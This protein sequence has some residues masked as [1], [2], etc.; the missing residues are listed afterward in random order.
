MEKQIYRNKAFLSYRHVEKDEKLASLLQKKLENY[1]IPRDLQKNRKSSGSLMEEENSGSFRKGKNVTDPGIRDNNNEEEGI[2]GN[3]LRTRGVGRIFRDT[4][5]L[6]ARAD[7][8]EELRRELDDSEYLIVLCSE[9]S[10]SSKWIEREIRYFLQFH[11]A[12]KILPVLTDGEPEEILPAIFEGIEGMP[13]HPIACDFRG[14]RRQALRDELPRLAAALIGC[15]YDQLVNRRQRYE[16]RRLAA[17]TAGIVLFLTAVI[18][19]YAF[20][21]AQIRKSLREKQ[22]EESESLAVQS[23]TAL[24]QRFQLDAVRYA[25]A[26]LPEVEGERPVTE[27]A[28][29]ALQKATAAYVPEGNRSIMQTGELK[30]PERIVAFQVREIGGAAYVSASC[31]NSDTVLWNADTGETILDTSAQPEIFGIQ[32]DPN[33]NIGERQFLAQDQLLVSV[34]GRVMGMDVRSGEVRWQ[35]KEENTEKYEIFDAGNGLVAVLAMM[36]ESAGRAPDN[37][38]LLTPVQELQLRRLEDGRIVRRM[39]NDQYPDRDIWNAFIDKDRVYLTERENTSAEDSDLTGKSSETGEDG[40]FEETTESGEREPGSR[41]CLSVLDLKTGEKRPLLRRFNI[42]D[43]QMTAD[44][45]VLAAYYNGFNQK[46]NDKVTNGDTF[47]DGYETCFFDAGEEILRFCCIDPETGE[48]VWEAGSGSML[49]G[50]SLLLQ[51]LHIRGREACLISVGTHVEILAQDLGEKLYSVDFPGIPVYLKT[52]EAW[53]Q[54]VLT[55]VLQDGSQVSY[56]FTTGELV[57]KEGVFPSSIS[58]VKEAG[59]NVFLL[60]GQ[61]GG[62]P[63]NDR[64]IR[65]EKE[66]FDPDVSYI[67]TPDGDKLSVSRLCFFGDNTIMEENSKLRTGGVYLAGEMFIVLD[68]EYTVH[69]VDA[70]TGAI[71]WSSSPGRNADCEGLAEEA[72]IMVFRDYLLSGDEIQEMAARGEVVHQEERWVFLHLEDGQTETMENFVENLFLGKQCDVRGIAFSGAAMDLPVLVEDKEV[73][74]LRY[75]LQ[76]RTMQSICLSHKTDKEIASALLFTAA[77]P[78]GNY[79]MCSFLPYNAQESVSL[80]ADWK[81]G[82]VTEIQNSVPVDGGS[83]M[84]WKK[85]ESAFAMKGQDSRTVLFAADGSRLEDF[86]EEKG[87]VKDL[88][89]W[90]GQL[91]TIEEEG[92]RVYFRIPQEKISYL[93]PVEKKNPYYGTFTDSKLFRTSELS[94]G[95]ILLRYGTQSFVLDADKGVA[96]AVIDNL[97]AYCPATDTM[98]LLD[99]TGSLAFSRRYSWKELVEK[100]RRILGD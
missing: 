35:V 66:A 57:K 11:D 18:V 9:A 79:T 27:Q 87:R 67:L 92:S 94:D 95:K 7:L 32:K 80:L 25:L 41:M 99:N 3:K 22:S 98:L 44:G 97:T 52:A 59:E 49:E 13:Q 71:L 33:L 5:D 42:V 90:R 30:A 40:A 10:V 55:A 64:I 63:L 6:G 93:L 39:K 4:T 17:L 51:D 45:F 76:D 89:F 68:R 91:F 61:E 84:V 83:L 29:L 86:P 34:N 16:M 2:A 14:N 58:I 56:L 38:D 12:D 70:R 100:G 78:D 65:F 1:H 19:Y 28:V 21:S 26:A 77:S 81:T 15:P 36:T 96:E 50:Q 74:L 73:W 47:G 31:G 23:E 69:G 53:G 88:G 24:S 75:D 48:T 82:H 37:K 20:M 54:E 46:A 8:T 72:G 43:L 62:M 85:D 60:C